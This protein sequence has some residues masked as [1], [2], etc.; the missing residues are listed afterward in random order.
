[1]HPLSSSIIRNSGRRTCLFIFILAILIEITCAFYIIDLGENS[2]V[3]GRSFNS[4]Q[5]VFLRGRRSAI[6]P[7]DNQPGAYLV[8][9]VDDEPAL[10]DQ[11]L[12]SQNWQQIRAIP[13]IEDQR[14]SQPENQMYLIEVPDENFQNQKRASQQLLDSYDQNLVSDEDLLREALMQEAERQIIE[15]KMRQ[16]D[17]HQKQQDE[18]DYRARVKQLRHSLRRKRSQPYDVA[19]ENGQ[20]IEPDDIQGFERP[21]SLPEDKIFLRD[22]NSRDIPAEE[23]PILYIQPEDERSAYRD[24]IDEMPIFAVLS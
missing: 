16:L 8:E 1:M 18:L 6:D 24:D 15:S 4:R 7:V 11:Q 20:L 9:W 10:D 19:A 13:R 5:Q 2:E 12:L 3:P 14:I 21:L 17:E 22:S 23:A